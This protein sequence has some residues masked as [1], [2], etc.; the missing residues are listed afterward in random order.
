MKHTLLFLVIIT[1]SV[2]NA[3]ISDFKTIDFTVADNRAKLHKG[4]SLNNMP[5][6]AHKLTKNLP[7]EVEKFRAIYTWVCTNIKGD[8]NQHDKVSKKRK[9]LQNDSL[10]YINWNKK[11]KKVA[12][13][14]LLNKKKTMCT[15]YAYLIKE[16]C[17]L[18]NIESKIIDGYARSV[19]TNINSLELANHSWNV[20]KL[21]NKWYLCDAT[22]SSGYMLSN[23]YFVSDYNDGYFLTDPVL[24]AQNHYPIHKKWLLN[25][26]LI[27]ENFIATPLVYSETFSHKIIPVSPEKM[28]VTAFKN[29]NIKFR[30]K[31][32]Q[33][34]PNAKIKL[35]YFSGDNQREF[36]ISNLKKEQ[37]SI[38]FQTQ[39]KRKGFYDIHLKI[40][41]DIVAT[42]TINV[43]KNDD[44]N[45]SPKLVFQ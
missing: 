30:F 24:F 5:L 34:N 31:M 28:S 23:G 1:F 10:G 9:Q 12:F 17:F 4:H 41:N 42:Y 29:E 39:I 35:V 14:T 8:S 11:F 13:K 16:L 43:I 18:A 2:G 19:S 6:L 32:L 26:K 45:V 3:Q 21:N 27:A 36:E 37:D 20:V 44:K 22:W 40:D 38:S 33:N 15:G 25:E 7:T